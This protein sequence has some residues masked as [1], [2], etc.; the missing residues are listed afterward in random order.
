MNSFGKAGNLISLVLDGDA[1]QFNA[2]SALFL[3]L[4]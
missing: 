1:S 4:S 3:T 2:L